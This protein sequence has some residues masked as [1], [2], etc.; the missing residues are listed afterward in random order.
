MNNVNYTLIEQLNNELGIDL[1]HQYTRKLEFHAEAKD[2]VPA[3]LDYLGREVKLN[4]LALDAW[5]AMKQAA[6]QQGIDLQICSA[7]RTY[8][9]QAELIKR[10]LAKGQDIESIISIIAPPGF[11][12]HHTGRAID[13]I[14]DEL[15]DLEECFENTSAFTWL[16]KNAH[17]FSFYLSYPRDNPFGVIY[18][19]WHWCF[20]LS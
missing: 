14:C 1:A 10:K 16:S 20:K 11:S 4:P 6:K 18:E 7:F 5:L 3:G 2:L 17:H 8:T 19:P 13:V 12:E 9:Y 15:D